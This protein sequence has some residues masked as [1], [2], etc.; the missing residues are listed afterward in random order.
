[1]HRRSHRLIEGASIAATAVDYGLSVMRHNMRD[2][3]VFGPPV[4]DP[5][6]LPGSAA[7]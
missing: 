3:V 6:N 7:S 1:M 5:F 2:L 4:F